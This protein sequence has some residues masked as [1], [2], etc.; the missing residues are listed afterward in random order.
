MSAGVLR[1]MLVAAAIAWGGANTATAYALGGF[2]PFTM[3]AV[4]LSAAAAVLWAVAL[5]RGVR[6]VPS[7][8]RLALLGV[9]EPLAA[10]GAL[11]VGLVWTTATNGSLLGATESCFVVLLAAV[12]LRERAG[13][14]SVAGLALAVAGVLALEGFDVAAGFGVGDLVVLAG[15][16]A[17]AVYVVLAAR[18]APDV[19]P[20]MMTTWQ[21]TFASAM[22]V[23]LAVTAWLTG[24]ERF[25]SDVDGGYWLAALGVGGICFALAFLLYNRAIADVPAGMAGIVLN[26]V[27]VIGVLTAVVFLGER[28]TAW[29]LVGGALIVGGLL[30]F[31]AGSS[32]EQRDGDG[33]QH[34]EDRERE[35][36]QRAGTHPAP[37]RD[38]QRGGREQER[39]GERRCA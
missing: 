31:P 34:P 6:P 36:R 11:T 3:L 16:L 14:R 5:V 29:H 27:P 22:S 8:R 33:V 2:G 32:A 4:K 19:D 1:L 38:G 28:P 17:A 30:L 37:G 21:F 18:V 35:E 23:P 13:P 26:L 25:P 15:S 9:F 39:H 12:F 20:V 24:L 10:Y 7:R